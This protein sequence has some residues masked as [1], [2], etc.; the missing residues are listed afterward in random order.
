MIMPEDKDETGNH[1]QR[2][3]LSAIMADVHFADELI[4]LVEACSWLYATARR[5][6]KDDIKQKYY[7]REIFRILNIDGSQILNV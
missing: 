3:S 2:P 6:F 4:E 1:S 7:W 5:Y